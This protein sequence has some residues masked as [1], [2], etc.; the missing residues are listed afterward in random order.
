LCSET[1]HQQIVIVAHSMGG[2]AARA[3][4]RSHGTRRIAKVITLGTP[5]H[6]TALARFGFGANTV[7]MRWTVVEQEALCSPWL[8]MLTTAEGEGVYRLFVSIFSHHDNIVSP[9]T[10]AYLTGAKNIGLHGIGHVALAFHPLVQSLVI[11]EIRAASLRG[12]QANISQ[13]Q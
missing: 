10:S 1:G 7:Q 9:Q 13:A 4:L 5:H 2:L 8:R 11:D 12:T 3:Y 6:G